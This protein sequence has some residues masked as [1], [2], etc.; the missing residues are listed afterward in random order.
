M[1]EENSHLN[2][3]DIQAWQYK[4]VNLG[5]QEAETGGLL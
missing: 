1:K 5:S 2:L 3:K 4:L